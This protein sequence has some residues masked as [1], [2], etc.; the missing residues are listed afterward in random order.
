MSQQNPKQSYE[1][2]MKDT[3]AF[4]YNLKADAIQRMLD[5]DYLCQRTTPSIAAI[6]HPG[7]SGFH[8]VFFGAKE[9]TLPIYKTIEQATAHHPNTDV[10]INFA[11]F[12]S[13]YESSKQALLSDTINTIII[14]AEGIPERYTRELIAI[15]NQ[16]NQSHPNSPRKTILGPSTVG[17]ITAGKFRIANCGGTND[18]IL[19][20]KLYR[21]GSIGLV[22][23]SGG[24]TNEMFNILSRSTDGIYEG[25]AIGG[26]TYP[27]TTLIDHLLRF[28]ANPNIKILVALGEIGGQQ[29]YD[30]ID[31]KKQHKITKPLIMLVPGLSAKIF[32]WE[33]QFGHA[34]AK[35]GKTQ[36][37][38]ETKNKAL[39]EAGIIVPDSFEEMETTIKTTYEKLVKEKIIT[40]QSEPTLPQLPLDYQQALKQNIIRK[41]TNFTTTI[42]SDIGEEPT[43]GAQTISKLIE[44]QQS[45]G[46]I[47]SLLWF[48]KQLPQSLTKLIELAIILCADHGPA[49]SGAHNSIVTARAGKDIISSL[50]SGLLTIGP[51]FGGAIDDAAR[52]FKQAHDNNLPPELFVDD[53]KN[54]GLLIPGIGHRVKSKRNPDKRVEL[55]KQYT[56]TNFPKTPYLNYALAV[57]KITTEKAENLIL[58]VDGC[59]AA[60]FLDALTTSNQFTT[61]EIDQIIN[62]GYFNALF[63]LSRS[64]GLIGHILDQKR[65]NADLYRHPTEDILYLISDKK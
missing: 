28:E 10:L 55:L 15:Q 56:T 13:A 52:Y 58:N 31:A 25:I 21:P 63:A 46:D 8:K 12:R 65:L 59:L 62:V 22:S 48:K 41:P 47:I 6:I 61:E 26:D 30:I 18:N 16:Y 43:Y 32:P 38:A 19:R 33:V 29:E 27:A 45:I 14:V 3:T 11:S 24:I 34:G 37:S 36:E 51:R 5:F 54:R 40:L 1:L 20:A 60:C 2:F 57:E 42:S 9:I 4:F 23:K 39:K 7:K 17:S 49:V 64:I 35:A 44:Q 53:M 50:C